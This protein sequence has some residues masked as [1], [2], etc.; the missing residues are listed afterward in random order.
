[1]LIFCCQEL[2]RAA[3]L[4]HAAALGP[5][6]GLTD[7]S[8]DNHQM[9]RVMIQKGG[10]GGGGWMEYGDFTAVTTIPW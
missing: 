9:C 6:F 4:V 1:M 7:V 2:D 3:V 10:R 5:F 8:V